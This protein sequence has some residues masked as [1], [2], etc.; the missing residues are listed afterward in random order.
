MAE[1]LLLSRLRKTLGLG[2]LTV[3]S[4][5]SGPCG[6]CWEVERN[7][8]FCVVGSSYRLWRA[9]ASE[10]GAA[11]AGEAGGEAGLAAGA[12]GEGGAGAPSLPS[13]CPSKAD[14][15]AYVSAGGESLDYDFRDSNARFDCCYSGR[16]THHERCAGGRPF[17]VNDA[18]RVA[19]ALWG[20]TASTSTVTADAAADAVSVWLEAAQM[21][22]ASIAA[23]ARLSLVLLSLDAPLDLVAEAQ[24]ASLDELAH[25]RSCIAQVRRL[26]GTEVRLGALLADGCLDST[27]LEDLV[28]TNVLEGCIG[29]TLAATIVSERARRAPVQE[30]RVM[31]AGIAADEERHAALA[32]RI[33]RWALAIGGAPARRAALVALDRGAPPPC[34][35]ASARGVRAP[36]LFDKEAEH[37]IAVRA[38]RQVVVPLVNELVAEATRGV[39]WDA[40]AR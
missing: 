20:A 14:A 18:P 36:E 15:Q 38:Y 17:L 23:F 5:G 33:L 10:A 1:P 21:E 7:D 9:Q 16:I 30:L 6:S 25:Y 2:A 39:H 35:G 8:G 13:L 40:A 28:S 26:S 31:F 19:K 37:A 24:R 29:E 4:L 34:D 32:F 11:G 22:H 3:G 27:S 12:P